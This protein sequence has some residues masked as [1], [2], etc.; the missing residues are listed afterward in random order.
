MQQALCLLLPMKHPTRISD[1]SVK[2]SRYPRF[3]DEEIEVGKLSVL[4]SDTQ[5]VSDRGFIR[6]EAARPEGSSDPTSCSLDP[7]MMGEQLAT[8]REKDITSGEFTPPRA[9]GSLLNSGSGSLSPRQ[10]KVQGHFLVSF[11]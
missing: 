2:S 5:L 7:C 6:T 10:W 4:F 8:Q 3:L 9:V 1:N 11:F